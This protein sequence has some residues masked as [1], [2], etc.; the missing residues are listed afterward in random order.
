MAVTVW[1]IFNI[2][3]KEKPDKPPSAVAEVNYDPLTCR[4]TLKVL[5][6][7]SNFLILLIAYALPSG[8]FLA[9]GGLMSNIMDPFGFLPSEI[10]FICLGLLF[11]GVLGAV[12]IGFFLDKTKLYKC[13]MGSTAF[14]ITVGSI[15]IIGTLHFLDQTNMFKLTL[16]LLLASSGFFSAGYYPLCISYGSEITF[17]IQPALVNGM[18]TISDGIGSLLFSLIGSFIVKEGA[19]DGNLTKEELIIE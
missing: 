4:Q 2:A 11:S 6:E 14:I 17:P 9:V 19:N 7:N 10:A 18:F 1:I 5:R 15:L 13:S 12:L 8:S 3:I 16:I